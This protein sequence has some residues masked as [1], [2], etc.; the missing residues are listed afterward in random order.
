MKTLLQGLLK[1]LVKTYYLYQADPI[2]GSA[3][4]RTSV[5]QGLAIIRGL[6]GHTSGYAVPTF[7]VDAPG[8]GGKIPLLPDYIAGRDGDDLLLRNYA[9][10]IYRYTDPAGQLGRDTT[11]RTFHAPTVQEH[12]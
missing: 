10:E 8:G 5:D 7:V 11:E 12:L 3:H 6:R 2:S 9:G 1:I 4:F